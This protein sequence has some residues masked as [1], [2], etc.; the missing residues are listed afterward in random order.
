MTIRFS[1]AARLSP[2]QDA[3]VGSWFSQHTQDQGI[4]APK[5]EGVVI[6]TDADG[7]DCGFLV[8]SVQYG[9]LHVH[10]A[11]V[12]AD[13]RGQGMGRALLA[14]ADTLARE[15]GCYALF[16]STMSHQAQPF[17]EKLGFVE[18]GRL[19]DTDTAAGRI[20]LEKVLAQP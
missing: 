7:N 11:I 13:C 4:T 6:A 16:L 17:Y 9:R 10:V 3:R 19:A 1:N 14:Q 5:T 18:V 20:W 12:R 2:E 15:H 8:W